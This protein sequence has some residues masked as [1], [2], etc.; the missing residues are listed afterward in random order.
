MLHYISRYIDESPRWLIQKRRYEEASVIIQKVLSENK[1][2]FK[3]VSIYSITNNENALNYSFDKISKRESAENYKLDFDLKS[4]GIKVSKTEKYK[5]ELKKW[6]DSLKNDGKMFL[7]MKKISFV[8]P[9]VW[10][11]QNILYFGIFLSA[12]TYSR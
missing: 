7:A 11:C 10:C 12:N 2:K 5:N 4:L 8:V 9:F 6:F 1:I 3:N